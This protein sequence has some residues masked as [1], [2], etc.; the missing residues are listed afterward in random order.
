MAILQ[1]HGF[2]RI[3][4]RIFYDRQMPQIS[5]LY[6]LVVSISKTYLA[7]ETSSITRITE[8]TFW[9]TSLIFVGEEPEVL[10]FR[11]VS[12]PGPVLY[13]PSLTVNPSRP[14]TRYTLGLIYKYVYRCGE[15]ADGTD[16]HFHPEESVYWLGFMAVLIVLFQI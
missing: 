1:N 10:R 13:L 12:K 11:E 3:T 2:G 15:S 7:H 9:S 4:L 5:V 6:S 14:G 8:G 16:S